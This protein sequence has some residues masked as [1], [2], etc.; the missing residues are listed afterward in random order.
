MMLNPMMAMTMTKTAMPKRR[1]YGRYF[2]FFP[3]FTLA[4]LAQLIL[5][6]GDASQ[7]ASHGRR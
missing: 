1:I 7:H 2:F 5:Q 3:L 4:F 6:K